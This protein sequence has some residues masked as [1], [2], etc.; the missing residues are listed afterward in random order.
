VVTKAF[1]NTF[2]AEELMIFNISFVN[3]IILSAD[4]F[5]DFWRSADQTSDW[6]QISLYALEPWLQL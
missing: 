4:A 3:K 1:I 2:T 5:M 6:V